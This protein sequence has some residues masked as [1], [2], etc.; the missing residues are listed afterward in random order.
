MKL[1]P[2]TRRDIKDV[3][4]LLLGTFSLFV[5]ICGILVGPDIL[6]AIAADHPIAMAT[7]AFLAAR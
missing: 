2:Q 4:G 7:H 3:V 5:V 1:S 6:A